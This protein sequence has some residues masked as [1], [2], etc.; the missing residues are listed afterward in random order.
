MRTPPFGPPI[1]MP[2]E[3]GGVIGRGGM[4]EVRSA[5]D[6]RLDRDVAIKMVSPGDAQSA[7][8][9]AREATLT[10]RLEHPGIVPI[11][12]AGNSPD[13]RAW[14]AMRLLPGRSLEAAIRNTPDDGAR[15]ALVRHVLYAAEAVAYAHGQGILHRDLKPANILTGP[16]GE[17]VVGDWGLATT[18]A[19]AAHCEGPAG[20]PG[21]MSPEQLRGEPLDVRADVHALGAT[22]AEV[23]TGHPP[24]GETPLLLARAAR[25]TPELAA[26]AE[27]AMHVSPDDR[28]PTA[29]AF[30][31]DLLAWFEG[32][33]VSA[34]E[35]SPGEVMARLFSRWRVPLAVGAV[36]LMGVLGATSY[37][38]WQTEL[39]RRQAESS[40]KGALAAREHEVAAFATA[41]RTQAANAAASGFAMEAELLAAQAL[42]RLEH[43]DTR[44]VLAAVSGRPRWEL[45]ATR[46][47]P[48]CLRRTLSP[49]GDALLCIEAAGA[50]R[51][52]L[53]TGEEE[54][55]P[56]A[57]NRGTFAGS[58]EELVLVDEALNVVGWRNGK[59][60]T[61]VSGLSARWSVF[62]PS[63][64]PGQAMVQSNN[65]AFHVDVR[66]GLVE[67]SRL[68]GEDVSTQRTTLDREGRELAVCIDLR[69]LR[70]EHS[71][72]VWELHRFTAAEGVPS[73]VGAL[74]DHR[75][76]AGT[77]QGYAV[78]IDPIAGTIQ[79]R[80]L[81]VDAIFGASF[82]ESRAAVGLSGGD[83]VVWDLQA[84]TLSTRFRG[85]DLLTAWLDD[86]TLR[87]SGARLEDLRAPA[88]TH[89]HRIATDSGVTA[90]AWSPDSSL[91]ASAAGS[92]TV[93]VVEATTG[94]VR[95]TFRNEEAVA[96]DVNFSP[97]GKRLV[98]ASAHAV[99]AVYEL[100][101]T[102]ATRLRIPEAW[103]RAIWLAD[104]RVLG[105]PYMPE[106]REFGPD[107]EP[108][109]IAS[110]S[111]PGFADLES[112]PGGRTA[113]GVTGTDR[114]YWMPGQ[115]D[116]TWHEIPTPPRA[117]GVACNDSGI[118]LIL[119]D[120]VRRYAL[121]GTLTWEADIHGTPLDVAI[122]PDDRWMAVGL[123][124]GSVPVW[125][126]GESA[127]RVRL[128]GH[129]ARA[130]AVSFSP[131]SLWLATGG[132]DD[133]VRQ[134]SVAAF[135]SDADQTASD[136]ERALGLTL[137]EVMGTLFA[138]P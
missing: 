41:L 57:W 94:R 120:T 1:S 135:D 14:Y 115:G 32:R 40:E 16:F 68:C 34:H 22:L 80:R 105:A 110:A 12:G 51:I 45:V 119:A 109:P 108:L 55:L 118:A 49:A 28:Y 130:A 99:Q 76:F 106:L 21:Y 61:L 131:D 30:A 63:H 42:R 54:T 7:A 17:T 60:T 35:Y 33:R 96:K 114:V 85:R 82:T 81:G 43:P 73:Y 95:G 97:D 100:A 15:L 53:R 127:P 124:D 3:L 91:L 25:A 126:I 26:I 92:G 132:W 38:W 122:S 50:R 46:A 62:P 65:A 128:L 111:P 134:W 52:D 31:Q 6:P 20:T 78:I 74:P 4:G 37:G 27:R 2:F 117:L 67:A 88:G 137:D 24:D 72:K 86:D 84:D 5:H 56:G 123:M 83:I 101:S 39:A 133:E 66:T 10:A 11:Y 75:V 13:G 121:D 98:V 44:G 29:Q 58:S 64:S 138:Q 136:A 129:R 18:L 79:Q 9:L 70:R 113:V 47:L 103:R 36:G 112:G 23:V 19:D 48:G 90:L 104:G 69:V 125:R 77:L 8:R 107:L 102:A 87:F 71:G 116:A 59:A 89:P 93:G